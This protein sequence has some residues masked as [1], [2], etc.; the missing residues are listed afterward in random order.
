MLVPFVQ[1]DPLDVSPSWLL[2]SNPQC[3]FPNA[4]RS[5]SHR[6]LGFEWEN[7]QATWGKVNPSMIIVY[8]KCTY[9]YIYICIIDFLLIC[10]DHSPKKTPDI[11]W[12][13]KF[14]TS[15]GAKLTRSKLKTVTWSSLG[16]GRTA[17]DRGASW[18]VNNWSVVYTFHPLIMIYVYIYICICIRLVVEPYLS[19]K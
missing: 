6:K 3:Q 1:T 7:L 8:Y 15:Q 12:I 11:S 19:E 2:R 5:N 9:I 18:I 16:S 10:Q 13:P 17:A 4:L 14:E